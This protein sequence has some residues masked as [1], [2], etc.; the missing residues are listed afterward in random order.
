MPKFFEEMISPFSLMISPVT[1]PEAARRH[2]TVALSFIEP[3]LQQTIRSH[4][5]LQTDRINKGN[6]PATV[7]RLIATLKHCIHKAYQ[8]EMVG[9]ETLKRVRNVKLLEENN[10]RLRYLSQT[11]CQ[12]LIHN[13]QG[14]TKGIVVMALN[15]GMRKGEIL[16]LKWDQVDLRHGFVLL[17]KT[18]MVRG[19]KYR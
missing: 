8:W 13:C 10:R 3:S 11:E 5:P 6:K 1:S 12:T 18:K 14:S 4:L 2:A 7:N 19:E 15:T 16:G 17:D 9:E